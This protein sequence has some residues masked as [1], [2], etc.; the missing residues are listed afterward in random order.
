NSELEGV[1]TAQPG[2]RVGELIDVLDGELGRPE[3]VAHAGIAADIEIRQPGGRR[4]AAVGVRNPQ[5][6]PQSFAKIQWLA[7]YPEAEVATVQVVEQGRV[8]RMRPARSALLVS[9]LAVAG[10]AVAAPHDATAP[11][12]T[13]APRDATQRHAEAASP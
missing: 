4:V 11:R 1:P 3:R 10:A 13:V 7:G 2:H 9:V 6:L 8:E 12:E 5:L